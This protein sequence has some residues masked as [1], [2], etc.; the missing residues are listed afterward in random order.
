MSTWV[1]I[2]VLIYWSILMVKGGEMKQ[3]HK[4]VGDGG[5]RNIR[6]LGETFYQG[7]QESF[8]ISMYSTFIE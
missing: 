4:G 8:T 3:S 5:Y 1:T 2:V 7:M 6:Q